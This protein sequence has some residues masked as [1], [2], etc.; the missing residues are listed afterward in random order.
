[1]KHYT[2]VEPTEIITVGNR[3]KRQ[4]LVKHFRTDDDME[5]E[6]TTFGEPHDSVAVVAL[7]PETQA[8]VSHQFRPGRERYCY[9]LPGGG[10]EEGEDFEAAARRELA[11]ETGYESSAP[12]EF[13]GTYSW[14]AYSNS[15]AHYYFLP[16]CTPMKER[17]YEQIEV[18]QGQEAKVISIDELITHAP[19]DEM[20]DAAA[21]LMAYEKLRALQTKQK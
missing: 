15:R 11:E 10:V 2:R 19:R 18:D 16:E 12:L 4:V 7:T 6:F 5:H 8:I 21:V 3:F 14:D 9:D 20:T 13:L 17:I 1:M